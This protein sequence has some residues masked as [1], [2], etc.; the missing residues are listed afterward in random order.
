MKNATLLK[1]TFTLGFIGATILSTPTAI[2]ALTVE[3]VT[4][5]RRDNG[6]WV[7]DMADILSNSTETKLNNLIADL[8]Q[9]NGAEIAVVTVP[10]TTPADSPKAFATELFN[11]WGIGKADKDNGVLFLVSMA[12]KRVEIETGYGIESILPDTEVAQIIDTKITPQYKHENFDRGTVDG[13]KALISALQPQADS[14]LIYDDELKASSFNIQTSN[15]SIFI[16]FLA[17]LF[18]WWIIDSAIDINSDG[19]TNKKRKSRNSSSHSH[20][21]ECDRNSSSDGGSFIS[22]GS[23]F[24]SGSSSSDSSDFG[25]GSS[26]GGGAGGDF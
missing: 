3:G 14:E 9:D 22:F 15:A 23:G 7:T 13:T 12:D 5:P 11:H 24:G 1:Q 26:D 20:H 18:L 6:G 10:E 8:E 25:G 16:V 19:S 4:N 17:I 21:T 2:Q